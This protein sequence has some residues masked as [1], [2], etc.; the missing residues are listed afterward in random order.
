MQTILSL[1]ALCLGFL[2]ACSQNPD[3]RTHNELLKAVEAE[4]K[5]INPMDTV[6]NN[7]QRDTATLAGGC[8]WCIETVFQDLKG[9]EKVVSGYSGGTIKN[10]AYKEVC[11]GRTGHAEVVQIIYNPNEIAFEELLEV[12]W[13][14]HD[15]TQLNRQGHDVG[16]QYRSAVFY[17]N[18]A[19][20]LAA[21]KSI[22]EVALPLW[23]QPIVTTL[24][25]FTQFYPAEDYHQN[26]YNLNPD[27]PY[28]SI[29]IAPKVAKARAKFADKMK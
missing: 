24:E 11:S 7:M 12:F 14:I 18:E 4:T 8:F 10:P 2:Y 13:T 1:C 29:V 23:E 15:P 16:T 19:Q 28:C 27:Q 20:R 9:V 22:K 21:E 25:A 6:K 5:Q 3:G 26:Y 17:H